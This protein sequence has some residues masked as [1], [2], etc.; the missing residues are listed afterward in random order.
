MDINLLAPVNQ[1]GYGVVGYNVLKSLVENDVNVAYFPIGNPSWD[2]SVESKD[3]INNAIRNGHYY[4]PAAESIR[5]WHQFELDKFV[6]HGDRIGWPIFELNT[7]DDRERH[8]LSNVDELIVCSQWAKDVI[9]QNGIKTKTSVVK[10]GV[11]TSKFFVD[12]T[13]RTTRPA[14]CKDTTIFLNIGKWEKRKG[15]EELC[16]AFSK[17]F[18]FNDNVEL[19]M[20]N[21][22]PFIGRI[23]EDWKRKFATSKMGPNVK[24]FDR[25]DSHE[26][27][28]ILFNQVDCGIFP[29]HAEGWNL[30]IPEMMACGA[31]IIA[32]NYSGHTE[33]LTEDNSKL[34]EVDGLE[35]AHDAIG[36]KWFRGQGEWAKFSVDA[37]VER[38][39]EVHK[40]KQEGQL[41]INNP[42]IET[43]KALSW[44]NTAEQ[45]K[46]VV[47][48]THIA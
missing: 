7:F 14:W 35:P 10:L 44:K 36:G 43:A 6:G 13:A 29:S 11:D 30:E 38:M 42:G 3:L 2:G 48:A 37:L 20:I 39:R 24:F 40:L 18:E 41:G 5:I 33:F 46:E 47:S 15:H 19:W 31:H 22:N 25:F 45:I 9:K 12:E 34:I 16:E 8:Q 26:H 28:R 21:H 32:T 23:N 4:N 27:L 1:L 17:A